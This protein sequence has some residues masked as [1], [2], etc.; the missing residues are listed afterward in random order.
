MMPSVVGLAAHLAR[1]R[2]EHEQ[3]EGELALALEQAR[4]RFL[5]L[6]VQPR[7]LLRALRSVSERIATD[8]T[9]ACAMLTALEHLLRA[10]LEQ[11]GRQEIRLRDELALFDRYLDFQRVR[12]C[13]R[14][15]VRTD[16]APDTMDAHVPAFLLQPL[17]DHAILHTVERTNGTGTVQ[18]SAQRQGDELHVGVSDDGSASP[19]VIEAELANTRSRLEQLHGQ[20]QR[21]ERLAVNSG[22]LVRV[23]LPFRTAAA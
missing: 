14:L 16:V 4:L 19:A 18:I 11:I 10:S 3:R 15:I 20:R 5:Q 22:G 13:D 23:V 12:F 21:I 8:V 6:E 1:E 9:S 7:F 2:A 17:V